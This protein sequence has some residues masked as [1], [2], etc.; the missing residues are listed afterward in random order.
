MDELSCPRKIP[1]DFQIIDVIQ[2]T[3]MFKSKILR[4]MDGL[5]V[6]YITPF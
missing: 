1:H 4:I 6:H 5:N 3:N 2:Y